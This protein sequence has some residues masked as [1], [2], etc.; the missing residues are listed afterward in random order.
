VFVL[1]KS[2]FLGGGGGGST[3]QSP[4]KLGEKESTSLVP[5]F[6]IQLSKLA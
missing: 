6:V 4:G 2:F 3:F 5:D 1:V